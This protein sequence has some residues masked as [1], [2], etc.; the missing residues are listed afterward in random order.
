MKIYLDDADPV[1]E[2]KRATPEGFTRMRTVE[3]VIAA[4]EAGGVTEVSLDNDLGSGYTE[5]F[6]VMK[7]LEELVCTNKFPL[8]K[9]PARFSFHTDNVVR[10]KE[11]IAAWKSMRRHLAEIPDAPRPRAHWIGSAF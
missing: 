8:D 6:M 10:K 3:E 4:I 7:W 9:M 2:P 1:K 5:G 11:M